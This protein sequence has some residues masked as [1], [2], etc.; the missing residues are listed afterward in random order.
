MQNT[1]PPPPTTPSCNCKR[2][3]APYQATNACMYAAN[4]TYVCNGNNNNGSGG[5][6]CPSFYRDCYKAIQ[7][8]SGHPQRR[9]EELRW[10]NTNNAVNGIMQKSGLHGAPW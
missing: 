6:G 2:S 3:P 5:S 4:G 9:L 1:N 10:G 8:D 7:S